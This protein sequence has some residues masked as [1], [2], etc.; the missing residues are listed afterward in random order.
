[1][2][3]FH[4]AEEKV[5]GAYREELFGKRIF[6]LCNTSILIG[7]EFVVVGDYVLN[8]YRRKFVFERDVSLDIKVMKNY[9]SSSTTAR[10]VIYSTP[11]GTKDFIEITVTLLWSWRQRTIVCTFP[12]ECFFFFAMEMRDLHSS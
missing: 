3:V 9:L 8:L 1:M 6:C 2:I 7:G 4:G 11:I 10:E 12:C 5:L